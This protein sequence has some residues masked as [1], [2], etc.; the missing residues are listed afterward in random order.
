MTVIWVVK[1]DIH[2][3]A[4]PNNQK[5]RNSPHLQ[6]WNTY[7]SLSGPTE[8]TWHPHVRFSCNR[9]IGRKEREFR[10]EDRSLCIYPTQGTGSSEAVRIEKGLTVV[11]QVGATVVPYPTSRRQWHYRIPKAK[12]RLVGKLL[13]KCLVQVNLMSVLLSCGC[14]CT[15]KTLRPS[16]CHHCINIPKVCNIHIVQSHFQ[17]VAHRN[18]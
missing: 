13:C 16:V 17:Y 8:Q 11:D 15:S 4:F 7:I 9:K 14:S 12:V 3:S 10:E 1:P 6:L 2:V 18:H 5:W